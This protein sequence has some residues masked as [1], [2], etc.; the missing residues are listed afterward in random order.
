MVTTE[1]CEQTLPKIIIFLNYIHC[2]LLALAEYSFPDVRHQLRV[3]VIFTWEF[4][5]RSQEVVIVVLDRGPEPAREVLFIGLKVLSVY[6]A[7][8]QEEDV[9]LLSPFRVLFLRSIHLKW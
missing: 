4:L 2:S 1:I 7:E 6:R 8:H 9:V 5:L 3:L